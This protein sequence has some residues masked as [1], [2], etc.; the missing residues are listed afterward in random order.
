MNVPFIDLGAQYKSIKKE[1][2]AG[3]KQVFQEGKF[4]LG[5]RVDEFEKKFARYLDVKYC[6]TVNSG[7]DALI[8]GTK[9][10]NIPSGNEILIPTYTFVATALTATYNGLRPVFVDIDEK[11]YGIN[12]IDLKRKITSRT[13][14]I[15]LVHLYGQ[16]DKI[17]EVKEIIK[18]TGKKIFLIED[19]AQAHGAMYKNKKVGTFGIF[20]IFSFYP[21]KNLGAYGDGGA[22]VTNDYA[23]TKRFRLLR[24]YGQKKKY[25]YEFLSINSR[26]DA[27]QAAILLV[28]LKYLDSWNKKRQILASF[29]SRLLNPISSVVKTPDIFSDRKS[30]FHLYTIRVKRRNQLKQF[31][32]KN[33]IDTLIHY[34][35]PLHLQKAFKFL[36]YKESDFPVAEKISKEILSLPIYPELTKQ[37]I[38]Y[39]VKTIKKF[40]KYEK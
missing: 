19:A 11:D 7:T 24:E 1:I 4:I 13:S 2:D 35:I 22:I 12:I 36:K 21:T 40:L 32:K 18:K 8:L 6:V 34:P 5:N 23:L 38:K 25:Y 16:P 26:F 20:S 30:V 39:I 33:R 28:K 15:I 3:V 31:L 37:Q 27:L 10:L 17:A 14:A 9:A 29:Y